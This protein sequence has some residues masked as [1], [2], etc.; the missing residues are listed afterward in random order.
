MSAGASARARAAAL[1]EDA[2]R[3]RAEAAHWQRGAEGEERVGA[4]LDAADRS[5]MR[6]LH[7]RL[8]SPDTSQANLDHIVVC[9]GGVFLV[10]T[11]N[12]VG[13]STEYHGSL[14]QHFTSAQ[15]RQTVCKNDELHKV[16]S[17]AGRMTTLCGMPVT[18]VICLAGSATFAATEPLYGVEVVSINRLVPWLRSRAPVLPDD[19]IPTLAV[20][21]SARFPDAT[22][23]SLDFGP[24]PA[25]KESDLRQP[26]RVRAPQRAKPSTTR[27]RKTGKQVLALVLTIVGLILFATIGPRVIAALSHTAARAL[28]K[29]TEVSTTPVARSTLSP[30]E[31]QALDDWTV[32]AGLYRDNA[33]PTV[34]AY[35]PDSRLG[36]YSAECRTQETK[37]AAFRAGLLNAPDAQLVADAKAYDAAIHQYL[38]ACGKN[39]AVEF[40]QA[41][42]AITVAAQNVNIRY[43]RLIGRDPAAYNEVRIL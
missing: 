42:A 35:V 37:V 24:A 8:L 6:V 5:S 1:H 18:P 26:S 39:E 25:V 19:R 2:E 20:E 7:D 41:S 11:K 43:N 34:L 38:E 17:M 9:P 36:A 22:A 27:S 14:M 16:R 10:D 3:I 13:D 32:R 29:A 30:A 4:L 23:G 40:H 33:K 21:L 12:W 28:T 31:K 15:G